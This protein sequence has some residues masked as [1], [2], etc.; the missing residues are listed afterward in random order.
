MKFKTKIGIRGAAVC[1]AALLLA[2]SS[3]ACSVCV[4]GKDEA[5]AAY[6]ATTAIL[7]F[8]PLVMIGGVIYYIFKRNR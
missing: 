7:S 8:L 6:Y 4:V 1:S 3:E 5:R 2:A